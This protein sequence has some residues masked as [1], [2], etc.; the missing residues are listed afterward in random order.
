[1]YFLD[2]EHEENFDELCFLY[3]RKSAD[4][5]YRANIYIAAV[6]DIFKLLT[7]NELL[8]SNGPLV[9]LMEYS[10]TEGNLVPSHPGLTGSTRQLLK[11]G[12]SLYNGY[13]V[14]LDDTPT[15]GFAEVVVQA[16]AIRY[17]LEV[18][19]TKKERDE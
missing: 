3:A 18:P 4:L 15:G 19:I 14:S 1:M 10:E 16:L 11:I 7:K 17:R 8:I 9:S 6:P 12:M 13:E 5:Q 2:H